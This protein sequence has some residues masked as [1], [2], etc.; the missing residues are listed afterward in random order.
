M[1]EGML[2]KKLGMTQLFMEDGMVVP[3]TVIEAGPCIVLQVKKKKKD[4]YDALQLAYDVCRDKV[5]TK[6]QQMKFRKN[7]ITSRRLL[8]E[9]RIS[10]EENIGVSDCIEVDI[11]KEGDFVDI[12]GRSR[13]MGFQGGRK[14]WGWSGGPD[15]HGS[16]SHRRPGSIGASADPSRVFRGHHLPGRMGNARITVQN[17]KIMRIIKEKNILIVR[18]AVPGSRNSYLFI[19]KAKKK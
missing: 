10:S 3:V 18:G 19:R 16:M 13:G 1:V 8:R 17:L 6:P 2:G 9:V 12:R 5:L 15:T 7:N 4:G 14:R 11:F